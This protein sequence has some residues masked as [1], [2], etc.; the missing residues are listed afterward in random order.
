YLRCQIFD[1]FPSQ[2]HADGA[3]LMF[4]VFALLAAVGLVLLVLRRHNG[5]PV[6]ALLAVLVLIA[7]L[8]AMV[9]AQQTAPAPARQGGA[10]I[11]ILPDLSLV[12]VGGSHGRPPLPVGMGVC[13]RGPLSA[14]ALLKPLT[15]PP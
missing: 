13:A 3:N 8:P 9:L 6:A 11:L 4:S 15:R 1:A 14:P 2:F 5:I 12:D 7:G 10:A